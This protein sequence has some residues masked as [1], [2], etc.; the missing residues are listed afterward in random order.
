LVVTPDDVFCLFPIC[1]IPLLPE[2]VIQEWRF[3][4]AGSVPVPPSGNDLE[5]HLIV[6]PSGVSPTSRLCFPLP[7]SHTLS[8]ISVCL[9]LPGLTGT[10]ASHE[11]LLPWYLMTLLSYSHT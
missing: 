7:P 9:P 10:L 6:N 1:Q 8:F 2:T 5:A 11:K 3:C 4:A